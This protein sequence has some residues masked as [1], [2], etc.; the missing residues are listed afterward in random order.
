M[1]GPKKIFRPKNRLTKLVSLPGG[2]PRGEAIARADRRIESLRE[3]SLAAIGEKIQALESQLA[4]ATK[5]SLD[6]DAMQAMSRLS[7]GV[8]TL[9]GTFGHEFLN[10]TARSLCDLIATM[11]SRGLTDAKPIEVHVQS[12][13]LLTEKG[14]PMPVAAAES[15]V[16]EL[17]KVRERFSGSETGSRGLPEQSGAA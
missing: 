12:M 13:R 11:L 2:I 3:A 14:S 16:R 6:A 17:A 4:R 5:C 9:S 8:I 15:I 10:A 1:N 7:D